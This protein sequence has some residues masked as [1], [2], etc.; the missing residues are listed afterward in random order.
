MSQSELLQKLEISGMR[1]HFCIS[2]KRNKRKIFKHALSKQILIILL[3]I[4]FVMNFF[5]LLILSCGAHV[6]NV[7][8]LVQKLLR[9]IFD[10]LSMSHSVSVSI[11]SI[12]A[13]IFSRIKVVAS[14]KKV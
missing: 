14:N 12:F 9:V 7:K 4:L 5:R 11:P 6:P 8:A 3:D 2:L 1:V 13:K 10:E